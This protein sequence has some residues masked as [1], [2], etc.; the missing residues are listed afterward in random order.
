MTAF[1]ED[2]LLWPLDRMRSAVYRALVP[3]LGP[4]IRSREVRVALHG[5]LTATVS[6]LLAILAPLVL[7]IL[8]PVILGV[9]H[10]VADV[11]Y[12]VAQPGLHRRGPIA[13]VV[14]GL[15][16]VTALT[17]DLRWGL[18]GAALAP[19]AARGPVHRKLA[20]MAA[21]AALAALA[22]LAFR[23]TALALAHVHNLV[24]VLLWLLLAGALQRGAAHPARVLPSVALLVGAGAILAGVF[25]TVLVTTFTLG[26]AG[27]PSL[28]WHQAQLASGFSDPWGP[29]MVATFAYAQ[30]VHYGI[31]LRV[32]PEDARSRPS[33][34]SFK[35]SWRALVA[36][37][38]SPF[39]LGAL[40]LTCVI[41]SWAAWDAT[42]AR[43]GYL[44]LALFHGPLELAVLGCWA[45][46]GSR[47]FRTS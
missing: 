43:A 34:R 32:M 16:L 23:P 18:V 40:G 15:L 14:G 46:E 28:D 31:W 47:M 22:F 39:M 26:W 12:L 29:R 4:W 36:D 25:D 9:P 10:L 5:V 6:L 41:A 1:V 30:A 3:I 37:L 17:A 27:L 38:G 24:A 19:L 21:L 2:W 7:L 45:A 8:S 20:P 44:R 42:E 11:R 13:W 33:P 35:A